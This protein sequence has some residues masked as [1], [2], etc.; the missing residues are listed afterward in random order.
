MRMLREKIEPSQLGYNGAD[1]NIAMLELLRGRAS[2]VDTRFMGKMFDCAPCD[3][4]PSP[5]SHLG[6]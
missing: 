4:M 3:G 5:F 2:D 6:A 1:G